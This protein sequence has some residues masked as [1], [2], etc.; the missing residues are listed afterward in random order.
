M[1]LAVVALVACLAYYLPQ[2]KVDFLKPGLWFASF[3]VASAALNV[4]L[5]LRGGTLALGRA[6]LVLVYIMLL[7]VSALCSMGMSQQLLPILAAFFYYATPANKWEEKLHQLFPQH[8]ILVDDGADNSSFFEGIAPGTGAIPYAAWAEPLAWWAIFLIALYVAMVSIA[9]ILRRQW[10]ERERLAYP[11]TQVGLAM[12]YGEGEGLVIRF[13]KS[14]AVWYGC[15]LPMFFGMFKALH[16]YDPAIPSIHALQWSIPYVGS[17]TLQLRIS[18]AM[19]GFSYLINTSISTGLWVFQLIAKAE[20]EALILMGVTSKQKFVYGIAGQPYLAYQGGGALIAMVL[21]GLWMGRDHL[22]AVCRKAFAGA[23]EVD[24]DDEIASYRASVFGLI[25]SVAVMVGWLW[26]MGVKWWV[27]VGFI[28]VALL[29]FIGISRVVAEAGLAAVRSPMIA[30][31]LMIHGLGSNLIGAGGVFNLS[32]A[33]IWAADIRIFIMALIA[34]G[35]KL[36]EDMDRRSR[37]MVLW[38]VYLAIL[39]GAAG[40][41]WMVLHITYRHGGINLV[42]WFYKGGPQT[43]Y[44]YAVLGLEPQGIAWDGLAFFAGGGAVMLALMWARQHV[45]WWPFHPLGFAVAANHLMDKIWFSIF[46]AWAIKRVVLRFGG[47]RFYAQSVRFFLGLIMGETLC[48][49]LWVVIDYFTGKTNNILFIL[50]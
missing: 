27:A 50:G 2:P 45:L 31:D 32:L 22:R 20:S 17:Q 34:N 9:V 7:M 18:F 13:F 21:V 40:S 41:C 49:G 42:G 37:R 5:V 16:H 47:P 26:L 30:P 23:A 46:V 48:N 24:D 12:V 1:G 35:L 28:A 39:I 33:Y 11:L 43:V 6:D 19:I 4:G 15:A 44:N 38:G 8:A 10:M 14:R 36:V 3:L 29:I 25:A